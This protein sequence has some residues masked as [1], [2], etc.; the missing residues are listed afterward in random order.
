TLWELGYPEQAL[1]QS[2]QAIEFARQLAHPFSLA[3]ALS[4]DCRIRCPRREWP[5]T[6]KASEALLA[7]ATEQG[8]PFWT[9]VAHMF[10]GV[11]LAHPAQ[12]QQGRELLQN[13]LLWHRQGKRSEA[14]DVLA[15]VYDWFA[16]GFDTADFQEAKALLADLSA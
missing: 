3:F 15:P 11:V 1:R 16:E 2:K 8:F 14:R 5:E 12:P 9:A 7:L 6:Q 13:A 4:S 10:L